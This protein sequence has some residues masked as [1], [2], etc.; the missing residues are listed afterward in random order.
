MGRLVAI[1]NDARDDLPPFLRLYRC[2]E[3]GGSKLRLVELLKTPNRLLD[4]GKK[5]DLYNNRI[6]SLHEW[7][8]KLEKEIEILS[9]VLR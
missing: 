8:L 7:K 3:K 1:Y 6:W 5:V 4:P 9:D 2:I